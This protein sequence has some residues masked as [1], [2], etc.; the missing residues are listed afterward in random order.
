MYHHP[1]DYTLVAYF[2]PSESAL[3]PY[4]CRLAVYERLGVS[5][6]RCGAELLGNLKEVIWSS[7]V[8]AFSE[9]G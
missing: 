7:A 8:A 9:D 2:P 6:L 5:L 1:I 3:Y 4:A